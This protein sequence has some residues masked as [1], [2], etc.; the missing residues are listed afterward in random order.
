[1]NGLISKTFYT[2]STQSLFLRYEKNS[3]KAVKLGSFLNCL[4]PTFLGHEGCLSKINLRI[5]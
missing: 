2:C 4:V 3:K 1:M 5:L